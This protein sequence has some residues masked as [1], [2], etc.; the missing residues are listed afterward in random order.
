MIGRKLHWEEP[1]TKTPL[2][3]QQVVSL[4]TE[5][6]AELVARYDHVQDVEVVAIDFC[7]PGAN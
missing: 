6:A 4:V 7:P 2:S 5:K 1:E 3:F